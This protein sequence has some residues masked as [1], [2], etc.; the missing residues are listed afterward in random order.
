MKTVASTDNEGT[1]GNRNRIGLRT[2]LFT[3]TGHRP[4]S[5]DSAKQSHICSVRRPPMT[6][7]PGNRDA[8]DTMETTVRCR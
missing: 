4:S 6:S 3:F 1:P 5:L 2:G 7:L 8:T